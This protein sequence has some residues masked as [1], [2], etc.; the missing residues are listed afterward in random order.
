VKNNEKM[1]TQQFDSLIWRV[2]DYPDEVIKMVVYSIPEST[3]LDQN[4][5]Y[6]DLAMGG[7]QFLQGV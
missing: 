6:L 5:T 1:T 4:T 7:G 3:I 2:N